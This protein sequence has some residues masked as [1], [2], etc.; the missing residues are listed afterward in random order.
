MGNGNA[1][2]ISE[3][4][5]TRITQTGEFFLVV[6]FKMAIFKGKLERPS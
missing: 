3:R 1:G 5:P 4:R 2:Q 6:N